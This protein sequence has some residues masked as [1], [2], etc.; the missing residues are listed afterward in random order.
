M[1]G[2]YKKIVT[3]MAGNEDEAAQLLDAYHF[4]M[5]SPAWRA[6]AP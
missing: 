1:S 4:P 5:G 3:L 6:T 2:G